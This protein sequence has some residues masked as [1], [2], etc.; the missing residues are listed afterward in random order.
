M[1]LHSRDEP[2]SD[3]EIERRRDA[4]LLR[5]LSSCAV[6]LQA[7][8]GGKYHRV[9]AADGRWELLELRPVGGRAADK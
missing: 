2:L 7:I 6:L 8:D 5:A 9:A 3:K 1:A 4:A